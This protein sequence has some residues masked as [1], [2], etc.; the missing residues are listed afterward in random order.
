MET[1]NIEV[2]SRSVNTKASE[3]Y[4][5]VRFTYGEKLIDL[6][7]PIEYRRTGT[8]FADST[9]SEIGDYLV[10][11]YKKCDPKNWSEWRTEQVNFW[12]AKPNAKTTKAFFDVLAKDFKW[13]S[14][15]S[16]LPSNP[17]WARRVQD[18]KEF[19]YT[20]ATRFNQIDHKIGSKCTFL[21]MV[22]LPRGGIS[23]YETWS[24]EV[25]NRIIKVLG[26]VDAYEGKRVNKESLLPDHKFP[27][28]RWDASV[29]RSDLSGLSDSEII[30]DFQLVTNQRNQQKR[31][32]CRTCFQTGSR[33]APFGI[34][35][36]FK[37]NDLWDP[38]IPKI[39]QEARKGCAGCGWYDLQ[40]WRL[41]LNQKLNE[42]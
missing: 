27:E 15:K 20:I 19:G 16:D 21:L 8:S 37:G 29:R 11:V 13:K 5:G 35:F 26:G 7:I 40:E 42:V 25:R 4:I 34:A 38:S 9:D 17:N 31:E 41:S 18:L 36:F 33:G 10:E 6:D 22:P 28:I 3:V 2:L 12:K 24:P 1:N 30:E 23:G 32:V 39:G 14:L